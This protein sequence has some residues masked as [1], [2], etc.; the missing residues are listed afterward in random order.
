MKIKCYYIKQ[1]KGGLLFIMSTEKKL[2]INDLLNMGFE[3]TADTPLYI[4]DLYFDK[5]LSVVDPYGDKEYSP[6]QIETGD[7][8]IRF[9]HDK[10]ITDVDMYYTE[11]YFSGNEDDPFYL[12][13]YLF[14]NLEEE[15]VRFLGLAAFVMLAPA[16]WSI[17][18][19]E[20]QELVDTLIRLRKENTN[21]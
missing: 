11:V 9:G 10:T 15:R 19:R 5:T 6:L 3:L 14:K 18:K 21:C 20:R 17:T 1:S 2:T 13:F 16:D 8:W 4:L 12:Y 7:N